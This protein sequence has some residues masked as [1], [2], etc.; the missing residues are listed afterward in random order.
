MRRL[1]SLFLAV[2]V[3]LLLAAAPSAQAAPAKVK[4]TIQ[5]PAWDLNPILVAGNIQGEATVDQLRQVCPT[6]GPL[7]GVTYKFFDLKTGFT[8][9]RAV[10]PTPVVNQ[11]IPE[12]PATYPITYNE[13]DL[14]IYAFDA[15]CKRLEAP[16]GSTAT[17]TSTGGIENLKLKK[18][19]RYVAVSYYSGP[20]VNIPIELEY[21]N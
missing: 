11:T 3:G 7:D 14:D 6:A 18:P 2:V 5:M 1:S 9:F 21:S 15:K 17:G 4:T 10:G 13:Y 16:D 12:T 20:Y 8:K 19:A